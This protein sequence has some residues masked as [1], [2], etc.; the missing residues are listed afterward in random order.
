MDFANQTIL[1]TGASKGIGAATTALLLKGGANV[2]GSYNSNIGALAELQG[3]YTDDRLLCVKADLGDAVDLNNLWRQAVGFKGVVTGLVNNAGIMPETSISVSD[4]TWR[5]DWDRVM[6]VNVH[7]VADLCR[8]AIL[9]FQ[10]TKNK[11]RI[12][13]VASR[14]AFRGD[15]PDFMHYAASKAALVGLTRTIARAY[16]REGIYAYIIAPG[17]VRTDMASIAYEP[18]NEYM[19]DEIPMGAA[20]EPEDIGNMIKFL[21]SGMAD[22]ATGGT[23]D[24]NGASYVR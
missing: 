22:H 13:N 6:S 4:E 9:H 23:F 11:G 14:A 5:D 17:W 16:A 7:A 1:V 12:I 18:G 20:A 15:G 24:I 19:L 21:L 10:E 3:E 8:D 2:V